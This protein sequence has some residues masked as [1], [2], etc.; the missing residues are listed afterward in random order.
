[1]FPRDIQQMG[2]ISRA[3]TFSLPRIQV[4]AFPVQ[5]L[6]RVYRLICMGTSHRGLLDSLASSARTRSCEFSAP[7]WTCIINPFQQVL[8]KSGSCVNK[9]DGHWSL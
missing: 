8:G 1:M 2:E 3:G 5:P 9:H 4:G 7:R 6:A